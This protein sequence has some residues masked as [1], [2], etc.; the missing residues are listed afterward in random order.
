MNHASTVTL[1]THVNAVTPTTTNITLSTSFSTYLDH[2]HN[3][4]FL[5]NIFVAVHFSW[6]SSSLFI[7]MTVFMTIYHYFCL[8]ILFLFFFFSFLFIFRVVPHFWQWTPLRL[9]IS[10]WAKAKRMPKLFLR[11]LGGV[12]INRNTWIDTKLENPICLSSRT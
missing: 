11:L 5:R 4:L 9:K 2:L 3:H 10:G 1:T 8:H 7:L 6:S 12:M